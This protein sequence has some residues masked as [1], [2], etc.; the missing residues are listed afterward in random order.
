MVFRFVRIPTREIDPMNAAAR[1]GV[2]D[3]GTRRTTC[4]SPDDLPPHD[5]PAEQ[6]LLGCM[7]RKRAII[8]EAIGLIRTSDYYIYGHGIIHEV[9]TKLFKAGAAVDIVTVGAQLAKGALLDEIGGA[10]YLASLWDA[11]PCAGNYRAYAKIILEHS[12]HRQFN[13]LWEEMRG[14][15]LDKGASLSDVI[16]A[17]VR[18]LREIAAP[19][20]VSII[21]H[22]ASAFSALP[23]RWLWP[24]RIPRGAITVFDGDPGT[25]K[26]TIMAD[27]AARVTRGSTMPPA[28]ADR[29]GEP[30]A[31]IMLSAEDDPARTIRPRL[32]ASGA[33]LKLIEI[34]QGVADG[35]DERMP[36]LP[37]DLGALKGLIEQLHAALIVIDPVM[38]YWGDGIDSHRDQSI[39][40]ALRQFAQLAE[41]TQCAMVLVR[42]L[43]K[44]AGG[45][46]LYRG[47]GSIGIIGA[48][49]SGLLLAKHPNDP[50]SRVL[51]STKSNLGPPPRSI[52]VSLASTGHVAAAA[53][54][55]E[56]DMS[57]DEL[58]G[59]G[60]IGRPSKVD[61]CAD[62]IREFLAD[63]PRKTVEMIGEL[64]R[65]GFR[66]R[67]IDSARA[68]AGVK[69]SVS[70]V[71]GD[72]YVEL[73]G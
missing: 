39:R 38:A 15:T 41:Q 71:G 52:V 37:Y 26:S 34:V 32:E 31:V 51:A 13:Q 28:P 1:N 23:V 21:S 19:P 35:G 69:A 3:N 40:F 6:A 65:R 63:G 16:A 70:E 4:A 64:E 58:L 43:N 56:I 68:K 5:R 48:A 17:T 49:R 62:A 57:A 61:L 67:T 8:T 54:G 22:P 59:H 45:D 36:I 11:A 14:Q 18:N 30:A 66:E 27:V 33:D 55:E 12:Q 42:H 20:S 7:L 29:S 24:G 53:W 25:G 60:M 47:G 46:A 9:I 44:L 2:S 72:W 73:G 10:H 50:G